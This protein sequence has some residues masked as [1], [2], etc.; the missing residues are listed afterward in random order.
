MDR[1]AAPNIFSI[2]PALGFADALVKGVMDHHDG[3]PLAMARATILLPN[4]RAIIAVRDAFVRQAEKGLLLPRLVAIGDPELD[5]SIGVALD[6]IDAEPIP[7]AIDPL[8]RT[9][10]LAR[11]IQASNLWP[12][13]T[14]AKAQGLAQDLGRVLDQLTVEG[15]RVAEIEEYIPESLGKH[16]EESFKFLTFLEKDWPRELMARG[17]IDL[18]DRRNRLLAA[19]AER[20]SKSPPSARV[21]AAGISS[22]APAIA[23]LL[24]AVSRLPLG[25]VILDGVDL[26]MPDEEWLTIGGGADQRPL[27]S[28]PQY[29]LGLLLHRMDCTRSD[30]QPWAYG[31]VTNPMEA[32]F[33]ALS[34]AMAPAEATTGWHKVPDAERGLPEVKALTLATSADEAQAIAITMRAH[35]E[36]AGETIA[37]VTPDRELGRRVS[38]HLRRW[39]IVADDSA[40]QPLSQTGAGSFVLAATQMAVDDFAAPALLALLKHP[41]AN[42]GDPDARLV[43]LD[44]VR[45]LDKCVRGP[46]TGQGLAGIDQRLTEDADL[47]A[48]WSEVK[49]LIAPLG[50]AR[51][52]TAMVERVIT[53]G[54]KLTGDKLWA[55]AD[56]RALSDYL[57]EIVLQSPFGATPSD[58]ADAFETLKG[59]LDAK[60]IR[61]AYGE[62]PRIFIWGLIEAKLQRADHVILAGLNE[63]SWPQLPSP[64]PWLAPPIRRALNLPS[65]DFRIGLAA[66][67]LIGACGAKSVLLTRSN[68]DAQGPTTESRFWLRLDTFVKDGLKPPTKIKPHLLAREI[69]WAEGARRKAPA[70]RPTSQQRQAAKISVTDFDALVA[71]PYS[72]YAKRILR[73]VKLDDPGA[74]HDA[75]QLGTV[76]HEA[77]H[78]WGRDSKFA[79][80]TLAEHFRTE[81]DAA[82]F[83]EAQQ[84]THLPKLEEAAAS[85]EALTRR[86][87][88]QEGWKPLY[89]EERGKLDLAGIL[90]TGKADRIDLDGEGKAVIIDYKNGGAPSNKRVADLAQLQLGLLAIM[91]EEAGFN[92][93][94]RQPT[95]LEYWS[96]AR[97]NGKPHGTIS[98][99]L[100]KDGVIADHLA[101]VE[102]R[103]TELIR[104]FILGDAAFVPKRDEA[105]AYAD[106]EHL[107][108]YGEWLETE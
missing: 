92:S 24:K 21:Y 22:T 28:H 6:P 14:A 61:P 74:T 1:A 99:P 82:G 41:L 84:L 18:T 83:S 47:A 103:A 106:F 85:F 59:L 60:S 75:K 71:D 80:G 40:G 13:L 30:V 50:N 31:R 49:T 94:H 11:K 26:A 25:Q 105:G 63:G 3:D 108:R 32:R 90:I 33:R 57:A 64:D 10:I 34:H 46:L 68:S 19:V 7:P 29:H 44:K 77:L 38:A 88:D 36:A 4:N 20:W 86:R 87:F 45:Q 55:G 56:G 81:L 70:P 104:D 17:A 53:L 8:L 65:L 43:W 37:L 12:N 27:E 23:A 67:D 100:G 2:P 51:T 16:W 76:I 97:A 93:E 5:D 48:W 101:Q 58:L 39:G 91:L 73:L 15:K 72:F 95:D 62:H 66:H 107:M 98:R 89:Q 54:S 79:A 78:K 96:L 9:M 42:G 69:D 35:L 102:D 52:L